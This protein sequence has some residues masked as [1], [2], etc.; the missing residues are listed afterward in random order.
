MKPGSCSYDTVGITFRH[1]AHQNS[2]CLKSL[3]ILKFNVVRQIAGHVGHN[4]KMLQ[5]LARYRYPNV[6]YLLR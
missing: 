3:L 5:A 4:S 6:W 2:N 1:I